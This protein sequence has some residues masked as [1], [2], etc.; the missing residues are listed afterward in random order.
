MVGPVSDEE[1]SSF[2]RKLKIALAAVVGLSGALVAIQ[3]DAAPGGVV[4]AAAGGLL[5]GAVLAWFILP[6]G[7]EPGWD[8]R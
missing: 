1:R 7:S 2:A 6:D 8:R 3:A 4:V 5:V